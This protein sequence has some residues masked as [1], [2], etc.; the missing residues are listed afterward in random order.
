[1]AYK[2]RVGS[3]FRVVQVALGSRC[4]VGR[5]VQVAYKVR[6]G[7]RCRVGRVVQ[8]AYKVRVGRVVH[9]WPIK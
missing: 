3:R 1:M 6:V 4:R 2:V 5:V 9:R 8:V 7:S